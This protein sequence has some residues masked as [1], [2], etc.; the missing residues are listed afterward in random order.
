[1]KIVVVALAL[2][3]A[4]VSA[5]DVLVLTASNFDDTV[6]NA[7][8]ILVE[9]Y[10]PWCGHCKRLEPEYAKAATELKSNDPPIQLAKVDAT[11]ESDLAQRFGVRGYPTLK[12]FRHGNPSDYSGPR[13]A[14]GI[15]S[16]MLKQVGP[17]AK[18]LSSKADVDKFVAQRDV[19]VIGFFETKDTQEHKN[20]K[21]TADAL[22]EEFKF[23]EVNDPKVA[24][25]FKVKD[26]IVMFKD[27]GTTD[28]YNGPATKS[29]LQDWLYDKSLPLVG[30]FSAET[31]GRYDKRGLPILKVYISVD[32]KSNLKRTNY[33]LNRLKKV[34][35]NPELQGKLVFALADKN[36][37]KADLEKLGLD[38][39]KEVNAGIDDFKNSLRYQFTD[40]FSVPT[41]T[42]FALDFVN[43]K[44]EPYIKSE[45]I[46]ETQGDGPVVVVGK[47][48]ND[49]VMDPTKDILFEMYAPW[50]GHC[51][52]LEPVYKELA[53]KIHK[54]HPDIV[55]AK[56]DAT[57]NDSPHPKYQA[58]GYP[59]I[60][61]AKA[62]SKANPI[63]YNGQRELAD[64]EKFLKEQA[65]SW[66]GKKK[67]E[68]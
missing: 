62:G 20:F 36:A 24:E 4:L 39:S 22:R 63:P 43:K 53:T 19:Q 13:E 21:T 49:I 61:F 54:E 45:P 16:Y 15:V 26:K 6:N 30:E 52:K 5:D 1:M 56:M 9:F 38:A 47:T 44:L 46:P 41:L 65:T 35:E 10:A 18:A 42:N 64:F 50:C 17:S 68:L 33:Y 59:T 28:T 23:G 29:A 48:F 3:A 31:K 60:M 67:D 14:K 8:L 40:E 51:K 12:V 7:E 55:I 32:Y 25:E 58:K 66:K 2:L 57:A 11:V 37:Y 27:D 34:A